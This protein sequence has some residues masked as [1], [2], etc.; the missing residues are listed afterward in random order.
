MD[1][2]FQTERLYLRVPTLA[3]ASKMQAIKEAN[4]P[5]LQKWMN[6]AADDHL[7]M[8]ATEKFIGE[9]VPTDLEKGGL[10]LFAFHKVTHDLVMVG[11]INCTAEKGVYSTGYWGNI[12]YLGHGYATEMTMG[13]LQYAFN[14]HGAEK[15]IIAYYEGNNASRRVIEKC[16][17]RHTEIKPKNHRSFATGEMMD[18]YCFEMT[19]ADFKRL[20]I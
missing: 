6:W 5:E 10:I 9:F 17:F 11:G 15:V 20:N 14:A 1:Y 18:E 2:I 13:T 4:W 7:S 3:D 8:A 12:D 19:K 16:G